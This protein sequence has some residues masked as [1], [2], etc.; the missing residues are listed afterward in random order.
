MEFVNGQ[1]ERWRRTWTTGDTGLILGV[2]TATLFLS[3]LLLF[4]VQPI[5]AKMVLPK[6]GGS[7][8]VWAVSMVFF[9]A[10]LLAGYCYAHLLNRYCRSGRPR[11]SI[12]PDGARRAGA[13]VR[14]AP[15]RRPSRRR[16]MPTSG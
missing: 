14:T 16:A 12:W 1:I 8:A 11:W 10:V 7:P 6:L 4:S 15:V 9:Q 5:F 13:A 3:A 2:F